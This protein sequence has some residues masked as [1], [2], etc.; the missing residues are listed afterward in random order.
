MI[1]SRAELIEYAMRKLGSPVINIEVDMSQVGDRVDEAL[2]F[3]Q[4]FHYDGTER[5]Y[6][7]HKITGTQIIVNS[8][9]GFLVGE[10]VKGSSNAFCTVTKI[11]NSTTLIV[12]NVFGSDGMPG[13]TFAPAETLIGQSTG[14]VA[15]FAS[16]V[17]GD[18]ENRFVPISEMVSGVIRVLPWGH[19]AAP[20]AGTDNFMFDPKYQVIMSTFQNLNSTSMIYYE[21]LMSHISLMDQVLKPIDSIRFNRKMG[22]LY[23]DMDWNVA[24]IGS[25]LIFDCFRI[26]DPEVFSEVYNDRMLKR[27]VTAKV[28]YQWASNTSKYA[29]IQLLG[30]VT[31]DASSLKAEAV[32]E[33]ESAETEI[34]ENYQELPI[35]WLA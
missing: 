14:S 10:V 33:I 25:H 15:I 19:A 29:G 17:A 1:K 28:K 12:K 2:Q 6:L 23:I 8:T 21:Q 11:E 30:G 18:I 34:R 9:A 20:T 26:L 22:Q 35:G 31:I 5:V 27:L 4:D 24:D 32:A 16:K 7:K 13:V 3:F